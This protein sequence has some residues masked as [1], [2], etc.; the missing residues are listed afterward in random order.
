MRFEEERGQW[1]TLTVRIVGRL[2]SQAHFSFLS[3]DDMSGRTEVEFV[4]EAM[5]VAQKVV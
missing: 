4:M 2:M 3:K 5:S 1:E